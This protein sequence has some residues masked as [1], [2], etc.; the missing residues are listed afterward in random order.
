MGT[1]ASLAGTYDGV[2]QGTKG[3]EFGAQ[4][5]PFKNIGILAKYFTGKTIE[6][7]QNARKLFGR[8]EFFF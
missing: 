7:D 4:Y 3:V 2:M 1:A 5:A 8:I 6:G